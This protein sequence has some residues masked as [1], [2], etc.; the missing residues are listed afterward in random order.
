[1]FLI[2]KVRIFLFLKIMSQ[3]RFFIITINVINVLWNLF[4]VSAIVVRLVK[5]TIFAKD[6]MIKI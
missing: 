5:I 2:R 3:M 1:M 6:A 4:G